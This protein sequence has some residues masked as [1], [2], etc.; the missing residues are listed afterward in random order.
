MAYESNQEDI[1]E[2]IRAYIA[3]NIDTYTSGICNAKAD[4][5]TCPSFDEVVAEDG[6][7]FERGCARSC[8]VSPNEV[9]DKELTMNSDNLDFDVS[10]CIIITE[11][12]KTTIA[13][14]IKRYTE[15]AR[16]MLIGN[17]TLGGAIDNI[18]AEIKILYLPP[19]DG[20]TDKRIS[21]VTFHAVKE[22][23]R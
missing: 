13:K 6:D 5:V 3:A 23:S 19:L 4:G 15:A 12:N 18:S 2:A 11:G 22:V 9:T 14:Q 16:Q 21:L 1:I 7:P 10:I 20:M 17:P 8:M